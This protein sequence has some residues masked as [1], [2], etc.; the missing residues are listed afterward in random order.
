MIHHFDLARWGRLN[1]VQF[2]WDSDKGTIVGRDAAYV[3]DCV[4][5]AQKRGYVISDPYP[6]SYDIKD[7]LHN[8]A[9]MAMVLSSMYLRLTP[10]LYEAAST[11][12][13][14]KS[15]TKEGLQPDGSYIVH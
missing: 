2:T 9:E 1:G 5:T 14:K 10:E 11:L 15:S 13:Q 3:L 6:S 4:L 7:P 12:I 8:L